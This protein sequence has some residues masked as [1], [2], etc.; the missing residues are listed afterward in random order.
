MTSAR[1]YRCMVK[2]HCSFWDW[3]SLLNLEATTIGVFCWSETRLS[4]QHDLR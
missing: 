2:E 3:N 4:L 1:Q